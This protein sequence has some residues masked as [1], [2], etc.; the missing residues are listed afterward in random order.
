M[1]AAFHVGK[2]P[3]ALP[4]I[5][6]GLGASL[7]QAGWLLSTVNLISAVG[8][9]ALALSADR[10]GHRRL[11]ILGTALCLVASVGGAFAG[12]VEWLLACRVIE[13]LGFI[14]VVV[15]IPTLV[16]RIAAASDQ[17]IAMAFWST[18]MP[19][20]AGSM[21]LVAALILPFAS[22]RG[23]WLVAAAASAAML[24]ALLLGARSR[25][26]L[27]RP[28]AG[29]RRL[30][31]E[32]GEVATS[33]GPLAIAL[34]FGAYSC[35]WFVVVGFLPTLL[36][37]RLGVSASTAAIVTALVTIVNIAGNLAGGLL[38]QRGFARR[39]VILGAT[40]PMALC[41][42]GIFL[43]GVP[44]LMRLVLAGVYAAVIGAVPS[45]LFTAIP[46]HAPRPPLVG[47][48]TGL[49]MQGSNIGGLIGPPITAALVSAGGWAN[50]A[51]L[52]SVALAT[53]AG[54]GIFLHWR[55]RR[56]LAS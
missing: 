31:K 7:G 14:T 30:L 33:G 20:G 6:D 18:Y 43:D 53:V 23:V 40:L 26:E 27:D 56:K 11:V 45:A 12:S 19:T 32:M 34:C 54:A 13:G 42:A 35:C 16:L 51:W 28:A 21:M 1:V 9:M 37:E 55:E 2:V 49:L 36:I 25:Q 8:G 48:A 44:D 22:W 15:S 52:T 41:A 17:R 10:F 4:S 46:V 39:T 50:A 29:E 38:L 3:P 5:R 47:A 24:V